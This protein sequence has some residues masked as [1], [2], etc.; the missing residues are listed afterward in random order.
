MAVSLPAK[1]KVDSEVAR[2]TGEQDVIVLYRATDTETTR[3]DREE[4]VRRGGGRNHRDFR[5]IRMGAVRA[6]RAVVDDL[7][8]D[9][10]RPGNPS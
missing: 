1:A 6:N 3:R 2:N 4:R 8:N 9:R 5:D 10:M 7:K